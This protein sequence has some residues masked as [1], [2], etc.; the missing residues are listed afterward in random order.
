MTKMWKLL[1]NVLP[2]LL[3]KRFTTYPQEVVLSPEHDDVYRNNMY[4]NFGEIG[5][6]MKQLMDEFQRSAKSNQKLES[7]ADMK[8]SYW[9]KMFLSPQ[10]DFFLC[11]NS[12]SKST[13][14]P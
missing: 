10:K 12:F 3:F 13:I 11:V 9:A 7:I 8:V 5:S 4:L 2:F 6:N 1:A 14:K